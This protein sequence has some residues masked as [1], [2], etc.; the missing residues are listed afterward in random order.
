M[1]EHCFLI[2]HLK[3]LPYT[4]AYRQYTSYSSPLLCLH[5]PL[6]PIGIHRQ[7][8]DNK[9][10]CTHALRMHWFFSS[11]SSKLILFYFIISRVVCG[12]MFCLSSGN[13]LMP[14]IHW[15]KEDRARSPGWRITVCGSLQGIRVLLCS[16]LEGESR[17]W[18]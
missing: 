14:Q 15:F 8:T 2:L 1:S 13:V 11:V 6:P 4:D 12:P 3:T 10:I 17:A 16:R 5:P 7:Y 18:D 9:H